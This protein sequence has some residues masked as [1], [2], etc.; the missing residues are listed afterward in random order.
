MHDNL[1]GYLRVYSIAYLNDNVVSKT[2][3][4]PLISSTLNKILTFHPFAKIL[5][6]M[7]HLVLL[8]SL[9]VPSVQGVKPE[10]KIR[11]Q[12]FEL[13]IKSLDVDIA[14]CDYQTI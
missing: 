10:E 12:L 14:L 6:H 4:A 8:F 2:P 7:V 5:L 1:Y 3:K 9:S 13:E 11:G